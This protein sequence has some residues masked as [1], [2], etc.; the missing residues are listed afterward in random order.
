MFLKAE[1]KEAFCTVENSIEERSKSYI[2]EALF[3]LMKDTAFEKISVSD[4]INKAGVGRATF[5][6]HFKKKEDVI[7]YY[8]ERNAKAFVFN[9]HYYPRCKDD[10]IETAKAVF[11]MLK[12]NKQA[13]QMMKKAHLEYLY[14]DYL[15]KAFST[16]FGENYPDTN[17]YLPYIYAGMLF[18]ISMAWLDND[19]KEPPTVLAETFVDTILFE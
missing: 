19:C 4:V 3:I 16:C 8:L 9:Q 5:Y 1:Q 15:N 13:F 18:N 12:E 17:N 2:V 6:R 11:S 14:L 10:Y 7:I